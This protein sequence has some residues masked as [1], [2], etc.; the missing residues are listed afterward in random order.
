L[1]TEALSP[2]VEGKRVH[3]MVNEESGANASAMDT[4]TVEEQVDNE[5]RNMEQLMAA[6]ES[7]GGA[8][9]ASPD[10][11]SSTITIFNENSEVCLQKNFLVRTD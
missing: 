5:E 8:A 4:S 9:S 11:D 1:K 10:K 3:F 6:A 2:A 7:A